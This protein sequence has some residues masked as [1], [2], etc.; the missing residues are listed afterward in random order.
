RSSHKENASTCILRHLWRS[1]ARL[2][3]IISATLLFHPRPK[4]SDKDTIVIA[5]FVNNTGDAVFDGTLRQGLV[6]QLEQSPLLSL[7]SDD[8]IRQT[9]RLMAKPPDARFTPD[10]AREICER[11]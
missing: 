7:I 8:R 5:D 4:V 2:A 6:V 1:R 10:L 11:S 9:L 3:G